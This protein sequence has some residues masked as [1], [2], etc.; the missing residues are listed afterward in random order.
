M[1]LKVL[2]IKYSRVFAEHDMDLGTFSVIK[3][4][5]D[6]RDVRPVE[7]ETTSDATCF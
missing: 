4:V 7:T 5:I 6:T 2:L 3:H 1:A